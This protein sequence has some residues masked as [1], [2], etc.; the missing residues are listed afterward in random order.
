VL[1]LKACATTGLVQ[2]ELLTEPP[3]QRL[4]LRLVPQARLTVVFLYLFMVLT[5]AAITLMFLKYASPLSDDMVC[6]VC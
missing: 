3:L 6:F 4:L 2:T 1:G 5:L